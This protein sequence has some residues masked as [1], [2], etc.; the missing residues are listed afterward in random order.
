[1][2]G[3]SRRKIAICLPCYNVER[4]IR[5]TLMQLSPATLV[6]IEC[7]IALDNQSSDCTYSI[8]KEVQASTISVASKLRVIKNE[9][10][11]GLGGTQKVAFTYLVKEGFTHVI[12][13]HGDGQGN[14]ERITTEFLAALEAQPDL[15]YVV[16]SR[17]VEGSSLAKYDKKRIWGNRLFNFLTYLFSGRKIS[18]AGAGIYCLRLRALQNLPWNLLENGFHF[19]P[20]LNVLLYEKIRNFKIYEVPLEWSDSESGSNVKVYRYCVKL[21]GLLIRYRLQGFFTSQ[22]TPFI[23]RYEL[24]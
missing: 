12:L 8:L 24:S 9:E 13:V 15:D 3:S 14:I 16:A 20:Q 11:Y 18:D 4:N 22:K 21:L 19:N 7:V 5:S 17:F 23:P 6:S 10:N 2:S 1:M